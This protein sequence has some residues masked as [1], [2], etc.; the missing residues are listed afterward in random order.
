LIFSVDAG[1]QLIGDARVSIYRQTLEAQLEQL[2]DPGCTKIYREKVT[3]LEPS[4]A[5]L[6]TWS[7]SWPPA[8]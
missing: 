6:T 7:P 3:A 1:L 2:R 8:M 5:S 4:A